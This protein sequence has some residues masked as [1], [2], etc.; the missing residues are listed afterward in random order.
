MAG[1]ANAEQ[2]EY[3]TLEGVRGRPDGR[4]GWKFRIRRIFASHAH[5]E[6]QHRA[7]LKR[8]QVVDHIIAWL[9]L[10]PVHGGEVRQEVIPLGWITDKI[11]ADERYVFGRLYQHGG[12]ATI[13]SYLP[14]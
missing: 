14:H 7:P 13:F 3:F 9:A 2:V 12:L 11:A 6:S 8:K 10:S 1:K 4:H 5:F